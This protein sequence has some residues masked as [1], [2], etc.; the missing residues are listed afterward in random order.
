MDVDY[1]GVCCR[2]WTRH[3]CW[4][5]LYTVLTG[6]HHITLDDATLSVDRRRH[7]SHIAPVPHPPAPPCRTRRHS[8]ACVTSEAPPRQTDSTVTT[9]PWLRRQTTTA[10]APTPRERLR[11]RR[12][13]AAS[14][15]SA[16]CWPGSQPAPPAGP[17]LR[18]HTA[19]PANSCLCPATDL[20]WRRWPWRHHRVWRDV[21]CRNLTISRR[22]TTSAVCRRRHLCAERVSPTARLVS[23]VPAP[24]VNTIRLP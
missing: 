3:R 1:A 22:H 23:V 6:R 12:P 4:A 16:A 18:P 21:R 7:P 9:S 15:T 10:G 19:T 20:P 8:A 2:C 17:R 24:L 11:R 5:F 13:T 14:S